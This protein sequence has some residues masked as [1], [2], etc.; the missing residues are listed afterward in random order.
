MKPALL[1][2]ALIALPACADEPESQPTAVTPFI[3]VGDTVFFRSY[4]DAF[5]RA[6][7]E[8]KLVLLYRMLGDLDGLT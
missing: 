1:A 8:E 4:E 2:L 6:R 7:R 3:K 5:P